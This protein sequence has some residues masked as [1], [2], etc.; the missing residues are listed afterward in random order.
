MA[1][2]GQFWFCLH[3][4]HQLNTDSEVAA[5]M[6][7]LC[8]PDSPVLPAFFGA[9]EPVNKVLDGDS[10]A[11]A[12]ALLAG[13]S[14]RNAGN[15]M[16]RT[17]DTGCLSWIRWHSSRATTWQFFID[18]SLLRTE[19]G[20]GE[21][22]GFF[23]KL[24]ERFPAI[25]GGGAPYEDWQA[26]HWRKVV[27]PGGAEGIQKIGFD[28][29]GGLTGVYWLTVLGQEA[30]M[31]FGKEKL[32]ALPV[33][34]CI[35]LGAGGVMLVLRP[36]PFAPALAARLAQDREIAGILGR[37]YFFD[38]AEAEREVKMMPTL[39]ATK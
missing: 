36:A 39:D 25:A 29:R 11:E 17:A 13:G 1:M 8:A 18:Q 28:F 23:A 2:E 5:L 26:K 24:C 4:R 38:I 22:K 6:D 7:L 34:E 12:T 30:V 21:L 9:V 19:N 10:W 16:L 3:T 15:I 27:S 14:K 32:L 31:H 37:D 33:H 35:D 20:L